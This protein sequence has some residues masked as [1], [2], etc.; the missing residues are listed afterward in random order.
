MKKYIIFILSIYSLLNSMEDPQMLCWNNSNYID[1]LII[2][3]PQASFKNLHVLNYDGYEINALYIAH[4]A[5]TVHSHITEINSSA[6]NQEKYSFIK[7]LLFT[8]AQDNMYDLVTIYDP[9]VLSKQNTRS[10]LTDIQ[11]YLKP[12]GKLY[13]VIKTQT[14][15]LS[16][17]E[18]IF[19]HIY[20]KICKASL[21]EIQKIIDSLDFS[22][23]TDVETD[24]LTD[25]QL[26]E[27]IYLSGYQIISYKKK[28]YKSIIQN[29]EEYEQ[30]LRLAF[31]NNICS[32]Q[33]SEETQK[34]L[35]SLFTKWVINTCEK[36]ESN[37]LI[38]SWNFTKIELCKAE[39]QRPSVYINDS[40]L[41]EDYTKL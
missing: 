41:A 16:I 3:E 5:Q 14:N 15:S 38:E 36:N 31:L 21:D 2:Y 39:S 9:H 26:K 35:S 22:S 1:S 7:N 27:I 32:L 34:L 28:Q 20:S 23:I 18:I 19:A 12:S 33:F 25:E 30:S 8:K 11:N 17:P 10:H 24:C 29:T 40:L 4:T 13:A 6:I 37:Q